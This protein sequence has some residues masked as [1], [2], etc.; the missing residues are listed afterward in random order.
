MRHHDH[1]TAGDGRIITSIIAN[2]VL[3]VAQIVGGILS[4][5]L[6]LIAD[7]LHNFSDVGSMLI[8]YIARRIAR[9]PP[10]PGMTF[11]Y[12]RI[13]MVAALVNYTSLFLVG[14]Y[15]ITEG[16][17]R[18][19]DPP[20]VGGWVVIALGTVALV[21]DAATALLTGSIKG[22]GA[23]IRALFLHNLS[24]ALTSVAVVVSGVLIL[25]YDWRLIDPLITIGIALYIL[26]MSVSEV[27]GV[28][29]VLMLGSP[30]EMDSDAVLDRIRG[31][32]GVTGVHHAHFWLIQEDTAALDTHVVVADRVW[33]DQ[34]NLKQAIKTALETD[35]G[36]HHSTLEFEHEAGCHEHA[37]DYG[38]PDGHP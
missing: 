15:L 25:L 16:V 30:P 32:D 5:S 27:G 17:L 13:E 11:G 18:L 3:T 23:N 24:D 22:G 34:E 38:G 21:V 9:R 8:A 37:S 12:G 4:G 20:E 1:S 36:I 2:L 6:A 35:F 29:R 28:I 19:S 14:L 10:D 33:A 31:I 7:A 26:W